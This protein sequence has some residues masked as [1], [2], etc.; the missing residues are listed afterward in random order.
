MPRLKI[1]DL[2]KDQKISKEEMRKVLGG[3]KGDFIFYYIYR[4]ETRYPGVIM[5]QDPVQLD[6]DWNQ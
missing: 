5:Q 3:L 4:T 1:K 2:P 6:N